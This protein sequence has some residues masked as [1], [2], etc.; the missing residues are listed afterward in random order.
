MHVVR[1]Y[2]NSCLLKNQPRTT[3]INTFCGSIAT[4]WSTIKLIIMISGLQV[5]VERES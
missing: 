1:A 3:L 5:E 2:K 4:V